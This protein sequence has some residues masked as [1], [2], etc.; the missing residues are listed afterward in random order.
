MEPEGSQIV[1][2]P[3]GQEQVERPEGQRDP[4]RKE[5]PTPSQDSWRN[6]QERTDDG[7][8]MSNLKC[9][10]IGT[11]VYHSR[12]AM[13]QSKS[14]DCP[15]VTLGNIRRAIIKEAIGLVNIPRDGGEF[16]LSWKRAR[17]T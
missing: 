7:Q 14:K 3:E 1:W 10:E 17:I 6:L 16:V 11:L 15:K 12:V 13:H 5:E 9:L 4:P 8:R 2:Q